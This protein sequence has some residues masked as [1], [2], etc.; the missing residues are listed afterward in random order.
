MGK[1]VFSQSYET[2]LLS[3]VF[4]GDT[5]MTTTKAEEADLQ[6]AIKRAIRNGDTLLGSNSNPIMY[7]YST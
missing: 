1:D 2:F 4:F 7:K 3:A 6:E 5:L